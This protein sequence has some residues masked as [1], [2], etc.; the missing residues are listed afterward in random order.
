MSRRHWQP[1]TKAEWLA[2]EQAHDQHP[3][4]RCTGCGRGYVSIQGDA[5]PCLACGADVRKLPLGGA[6]PT[7][8]EPS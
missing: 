2:W 7:L 1:K 3:V 6:V 8:A 4:A 5:I